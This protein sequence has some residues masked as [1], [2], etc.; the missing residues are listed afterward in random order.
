LKEEALYRIT[1]RTRKTKCTV[2]LHDNINLM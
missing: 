2:I 1:W